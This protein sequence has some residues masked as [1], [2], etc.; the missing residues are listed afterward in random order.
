MPKIK[1]QTEVLLALNRIEDRLQK[2][3]DILKV[4]HRE[5]IEAAQRKI[6]VGSPLRKKIYDLCDGSRSVGQIAG[7]LGKSIQQVSNNIAHLQNVGLIK[8]V[9]RGKEKFYTKSG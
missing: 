8:E 5:T 2:V 1:D 4:G 3:A 7:I 9:R 6:L